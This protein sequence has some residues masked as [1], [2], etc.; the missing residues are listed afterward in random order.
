MLVWE[1]LAQNKYTDTANKKTLAKSIASSQTIV[2]FWEEEIKLRRALAVVFA[3]M[4]VIFVFLSL[5]IP[6]VKATWITRTVDYVLAEPGDIVGVGQEI[7]FTA[8]ISPAPGGDNSFTELYFQVTYPDGGIQNFGSFSSDSEGLLSWGYEFGVVGSY[9]IVLFSAHVDD[10]GSDSYSNFSSGRAYFTVKEEPVMYYDFTIGH[11]GSGVVS[12]YEGARVQMEG[13]GVT[14]LAEADS[15]WALNYWLLDDVNVGRGNWLSTAEWEYGVTMNSDHSLLAV[16]YQPAYTLT[17]NVVGSGSVVKRPNQETY[18]HGSV[19]TLTADPESGWSFSGWSGASSDNSNL[20][21]ITM[22]G[23]KTVTATFEHELAQSSLSITTSSSIMVIG[24]STTVSGSLFPP[25]SNV[26]LSIQCREGDASWSTLQ[27]V[28]SD[29]NGWFSYS[30]ST[31]T[32]GDYEVRVTWGGD[33][34]TLPCASQALPLTVSSPPPWELYIL[35]GAIGTFAAV[36]SVGL[37]VNWW[38]K[39]RALKSANKACEKLSKDLG[40]E[41]YEQTLEDLDDLIEKVEKLA[42]T[43]GPLSEINEPPYSVADNLKSIKKTLSEKPSEETMKEFFVRSEIQPYLSGLICVLNIFRN[44]KDFKPVSRA[45]SP[46]RYFVPLVSRE[47]GAFDKVNQVE[48]RDIRDFWFVWEKEEVEPIRLYFVNGKMVGARSRWHWRHIDILKP[49]VNDKGKIE[50]LILP[51]F[52]TPIVRRSTE[53]VLFLV[54][55]KCFCVVV[56]DYKRVLNEKVNSK[57]TEPGRKD[58]HP[59]PYD[60]PG[61]EEKFKYD[62]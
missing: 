17:V 10:I 59:P 7:R 55:A 24:E 52:H 47:A 30:L 39:A 23:D 1:V 32:A 51:Q 33:A 20:I 6:A 11:I 9:S 21:T 37:T 3:V 45:D 35:I 42:S 27:V 15:G 36:P 54:F 53:D 46:S 31:L 12:P 62:L 56:R 16:F 26:E 43:A 14:V 4:F 34:A 13:T 25:L 28:R 40:E 50:V 19:V 49:Y 58:D 41:N 2:L 60:Y 38:W 44:L 48:K 57:Y 5:A 61:W 8:R 18:G 29:S 22:D